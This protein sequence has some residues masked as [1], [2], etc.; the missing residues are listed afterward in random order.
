MHREKGVLALHHWLQQSNNAQ[1]ISFRN[2]K[3]RPILNINSVG[4]TKL[5]P[6]KQAL[7]FLLKHTHFI[8]EEGWMV[9]NFQIFPSLK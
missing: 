4:K 1:N 3:W 6:T 8:G 5:C 9:N 2:F 7:Q